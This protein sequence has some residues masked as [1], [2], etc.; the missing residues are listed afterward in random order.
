MLS[1]DGGG[2][3]GTAGAWLVDPGPVALGSTFR[4]VLALDPAA[5]A[6]GRPVTVAIVFDPRMAYCVAVEPPPPGGPS[7][8]SDV[9]IAL[10]R[11]TA[12]VT[13]GE[14][15]T[16]AD[17]VA[18]ATVQWRCVGEGETRVE[19]QLRSAAGEASSAVTIVQHPRG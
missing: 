9:T 7:V 17:H 14:G 18:V 13:I 10:G 2:P 1:R 3:G 11:V 5:A 12:T 8:A 4:T 19:T 15:G 6:P 16:P